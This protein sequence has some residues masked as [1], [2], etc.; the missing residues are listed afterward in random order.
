MVRPARL[1]RAELPAAERTPDIPPDPT[2]SRPVDDNQ[3]LNPVSEPD[4]LCA[5]DEAASR[6]YGNKYSAGRM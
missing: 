5:F 2:R 6:G 4:N 3:N 1:L